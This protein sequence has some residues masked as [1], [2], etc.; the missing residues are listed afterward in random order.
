MDFL[1][2]DYQRVMESMDLLFG[3]PHC[4]KRMQVPAAYSGREVKCFSCEAMIRVPADGQRVM[5]LVPG[6]KEK[7]RR[8][9]RG[10]LIGAVLVISSLGL[11]LSVFSSDGGSGGMDDADLKSE[12]RMW[13]RRNILDPDAQ[14]IHYYAWEGPEGPEVVIR[15]RGKNAFGGYVANRFHLM[16]SESGQVIGSRRM[17]D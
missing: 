16:F 7:R 11:L 13:V 6:K 1:Q 8:N 14:I 12:A 17:E 15:V 10:W 4:K 5:P 3:C 9:I 2:G